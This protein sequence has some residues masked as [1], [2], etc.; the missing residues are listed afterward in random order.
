MQNQKSQ[1]NIRRIA[2]TAL[3]T[4]TLL[5][6][7]VPIAA[8]IAQDD[9]LTAVYAASKTVKVSFNSL[10]GKTVKAKSIKA[11]SKIGK[12]KTSSRAGYDFKG[13]YT[14][15]NG[16]A[17]IKST[18]KVKKAV[19][20]YAHWKLK[21]SYVEIKF[22]S[23]GGSSV[24]AKSIKK[25]K[26]AG[27]L[28][29]PK[30]TGYTFKGWYTADSGGK[31]ITASTKISKSQTVH[32]R[33]AINNYTLTFDAQ[34]GN[35]VA[36]KKVRYNYSY[37]M[38]HNSNLPKPG[39][40]GY[41]FAGW[42][43]A[44]TGGTQFVAD[45]KVTKS[46]TLYAKWTES[47][48]SVK[49]LYIPI[50]AS[51]TAP[52]NK[53]FK[54]TVDELQV[55]NSNLIVNMVDSAYNPAKQVEHISKGVEE[56]YDGILI[57]VMNPTLT[58]EPI[59]AAEAAGI[60][61][62]TINLGSNAIHSQHITHDDYAVGVQAANILGAEIGSSGKY[63]TLNG[64]NGDSQ[65]IAGFQ[66]KMASDF[67]GCENLGDIPIAGWDIS[68]AK[69]QMAIALNSF[70]TI[71]AVFTAS[72]DLA[73][74]AIEAIAEAG[75][76]GEIKVYAAAGYP[77]GLQRIK[78]GTEFGHD[79]LDYY[80]EY[81]TAINNTLEFIQNG[82]TAKTLNLTSTPV[83]YMPPFPVTKNGVQD[84]AAVDAAIEASRW[85]LVLPDVFNQ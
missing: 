38:E 76:A 5:V 60:P 33:W 39:K 83:F 73:R 62:V 43:T 14:K 7:G 1:L 27:T 67:P 54:Y 84:T 65:N 64:P 77:D 9:S 81:K 12:L 74:G 63:L 68:N 55:S 22:D 66:E 6:M 26:K 34:G 11:N 44:K 82:Q 51:T 70:S 4:L 56:G 46:L 72:D 48:D 31:Q 37:K 16:G 10:G 59:E 17:K 71:N 8:G 32:A 36:P 18:T 30:K 28:A 58:K 24:Y 45:T 57:E 15:A 52:N 42:Y 53:V 41:D 61:V 3:L 47:S 75:R 49:L 35:T 69:T 78:N 85:A 50:S 80:G 20:Y 25:G 13:W 2:F 79:L 40:V 19:T 23:N 21:K 29:T